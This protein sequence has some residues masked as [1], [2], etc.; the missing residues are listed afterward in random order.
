MEAA[1]APELNTVLDAATAARSRVA[2]DN[3]C[4]LGVT[5]DRTYLREQRHLIRLLNAM[6]QTGADGF[7][8]RS[9]HTQLPPVDD[10]LYLEGLREVVETC[11]ANRSAFSCRRQAGSGGLPWAGAPGDSAEA[12]PRGRGLIGSRRR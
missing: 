9:Q 6:I 10:P 4:W 2:A 1:R 12:W 3:D 8:F 11:A 5:V 7:V